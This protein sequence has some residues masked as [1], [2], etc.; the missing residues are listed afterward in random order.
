MQEV[1][2][3]AQDACMADAIK[4]AAGAKDSKSDAAKDLQARVKLLEVCI[5]GYIFSMYCPEKSATFRVPTPK[6]SQILVL[7]RSMLR[8]IPT[9]GLWCTAWCGMMVTCTEPPWTLPT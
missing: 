7:R 8:N 1:W 4:A 2:Q 9:W 3:K 5:F 6:M